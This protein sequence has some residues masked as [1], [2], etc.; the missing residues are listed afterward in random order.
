M[1]QPPPP[2]LP[3]GSRPATFREA[4]GIFPGVPWQTCYWVP[5][6]GS[7]RGG[8]VVAPDGRMHPPQPLAS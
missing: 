8:Y 6:R 7:L 5:I 1:L 4:A 3:E 2:T